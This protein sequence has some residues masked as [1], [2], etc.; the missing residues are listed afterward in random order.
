LTTRQ[1][2]ASLHPSQDAATGS[3][4]ESVLCLLLLLLLPPLLL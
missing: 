3:N 1:N 2:Y 4:A